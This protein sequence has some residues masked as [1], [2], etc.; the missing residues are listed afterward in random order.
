MKRTIDEELV[1]SEH[2]KISW[3]YER[4]VVLYTV[5]SIKRDVIDLW[6]EKVHEVMLA[7]EPNTVYYNIHDYSRVNSFVTTPHLRQKSK[8]SALTRLDLSARTAV[9]IPKSVM[10]P[11]TRL[12]INALPHP[13]NA[14][15]IREMFF[16][17]DDGLAWLERQ[18]AE[19][20]HK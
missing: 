20:E 3:M 19:M 15:R 13:K 14:D 4:R 8:E 7:W 2:L 1:I 18:M 5:T 12:F 9:V 6:A 17:V 16:T 10:S 11:I